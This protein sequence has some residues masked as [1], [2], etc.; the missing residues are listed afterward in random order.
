MSLEVLGSLDF[1]QS[2]MDAFKLAIITNEIDV[3]AH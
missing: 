2:K 1:Q 3:C